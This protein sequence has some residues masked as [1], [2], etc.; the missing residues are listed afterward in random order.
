MKVLKKSLCIFM[1]VVVLFFSINNSYFS[2]DKM[3][4]VEASSLVVGGGVVITADLI[5]KIIS[6]LA[7]AGLTAGVI[8]EWKDMDFE[9][10]LE[11]FHSWLRENTA[12]LDSLNI[13]GT[14]ALKEWAESDTWVVIEGGGGS[15]EPSP[16]PDGNEDP[17]P[18]TH[19]G[20]KLWPAGTSWTIGNLIA[21][22]GIM[23][24]QVYNQV[25]TADKDTVAVAQAYIKDKVA[26]FSGNDAGTDPVT[27][28][29]QSRY[30]VNDSEPHY[31][32]QY[33]MV[34]NQYSISAHGYFYFNN[35]YY[36]EY[37]FTHYLTN[38]LVAGC[39]NTAGSDVSFYYLNNNSI[40]VLNLD[41][42]WV[43]YNPDGTVY[44]EA[45]IEGSGISNSKGLA[46]YSVNFPIFSSYDDMKSYLLGESDDSNCI[47]RER[48]QNYIDT[49]DDYGWAS[50]AAIDPA[51]IPAA[52]PDLAESL[53]GRDVSIAALVNAIESLKNQLEEQNP[54]T[55]PA[56]DPVPYPTIA[57]YADTL[58]D[59]ITDPDIFPESDPAVDPAP[60]PDPGTETAPDS[61]TMKDYSGFLGKIITLLQNILQAIKDFFAWFIIDFDAIKQ[62]LLL[63]LS[64]VPAFSGYEDFLALIDS[65]KEQITDSYDYPV[66]EMDTPEILLPYYKHATIVLLDFEDYATYFIWVRTAMSFAI[67]FGFCMWV[68]R[69]IKVSFTLN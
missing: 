2:P 65:A 39:I 5:I 12:V 36:D 38:N 21:A 64:S 28:A 53:D 54:N 3:D 29:L 69:D 14:S 55:D 16:S 10:V 23:A 46:S 30:I 52:M 26:S 7:I 56:V 25:S 32:G 40:A 37:K 15:S 48:K 57:D 35:G 31:C 4:T 59:V 13:D 50:S 24:E 27:Q 68:I 58:Q 9:A 1:S 49:S 45:N 61:D 6:A 33:E 20:E 63:V 51:A 42:H 60:D 43:R 11:D 34:E 18:S 17:E 41:Y 8:I 47:N 62:H 66:I 67:L 22:G 19:G 44:Y